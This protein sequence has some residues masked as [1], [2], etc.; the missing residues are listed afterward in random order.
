MSGVGVTGVCAAGSAAAYALG[1]TRGETPTPSPQRRVAVPD[2]RA[3]PDAP[4]G[5]RRFARPRE[6]VLRRGGVRAHPRATV[7][8]VRV[9][10]P[11]TP[12]SR[13]DDTGP[14]DH[15]TSCQVGISATSIAVGIVA[16]PA[17]TSLIAPAFE[18]TLLASVGA[19]GV[20][21]FVVINLLHLTHGEQTPTYLGVERTKFVAWYGATPPYW[22]AKL[23]YPVVVLGASV[24]TWTLGLFG[25]EVTGGWL[26]TEPDRVEPRADLRHR[27]GALLNRGNLSEERTAEI[28][29]AFAVGE[30]PQRH[31]DRPRGRRPSRRSPPGAPRPDRREPAHAVL[32]GRQRPGGLLRGRLRPRGRR[33]DRRTPARRGHV[34]GYR[35]LTGDAPRQTRSSATPSTGFGTNTMRPRSCP[36]PTRGRRWG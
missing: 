19:G 34:R 3:R 7:S 18:R 17:P 29:N 35:R 33:S 9:R 11:G 31:R 5:R 26:A 16:E 23:R 2:G 15:L 28:P 36:T 21:A 13:G 4:P 24:A 32:A 10:R 6:R 8:R 1:A 22:F 25:V 30:R 27:L 20:L 12:A 14:R